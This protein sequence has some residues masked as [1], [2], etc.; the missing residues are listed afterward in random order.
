MADVLPSQEPAPAPLYRKPLEKGE[1]NKGV[2]K[3]DEADALV[4]ILLTPVNEKMAAADL[5][6]LR[7][8]MVKQSAQ[9]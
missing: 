4:A 9:L 8:E 7:A 1:Q 3:K 5:E 2:H 6:K